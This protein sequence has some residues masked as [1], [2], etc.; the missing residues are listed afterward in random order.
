MSSQRRET[1][2][3]VTRVSAGTL[4][5][6]LSVAVGAGIGYLLDT[7]VFGGRTTPWLTLFWLLCGVIAGFRSL[8]RVMRELEREGEQEGNGN[9]PR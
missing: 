2:R 9:P 8:L 6:G 3:L 5:L 1:M 4:E 7:R